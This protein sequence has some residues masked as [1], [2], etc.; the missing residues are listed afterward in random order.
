MILK[1]ERIKYWAETVVC[2]L[3]EAAIESHAM[4]REIE[5]LREME[6]VAGNIKTDGRGQVM[7]I[8]GLLEVLAKYQAL[9]EAP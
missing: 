3:G 8:V 4:A 7:A 9:K 2:P 6:R 5:V 1:D